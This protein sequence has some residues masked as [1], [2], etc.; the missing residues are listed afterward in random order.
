MGVSSSSQLN[1]IVD[2]Y[3]YFNKPVNCY[4]EDGRLAGIIDLNNQT[5]K[6]NVS[7]EDSDSLYQFITPS[8]CCKHKEPNLNFYNVKLK[9]V[10]PFSRDFKLVASNDTFKIFI[11]IIDVIDNPYAH[12]DLKYIVNVKLG[13][14]FLGLC[15]LNK[16]GNFYI[17]Q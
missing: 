16:F 4:Y 15:T 1:C 3:P 13:D 5:T 6:W 2:R 11:S 7:D 17:N 8:L 10:D 14:T 9:E 12:K